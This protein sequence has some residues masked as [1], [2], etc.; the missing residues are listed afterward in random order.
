MQGYYSSE[1][2]NQEKTHRVLTVRLILHRC[3]S[4]ILTK[5]SDDDMSTEARQEGASA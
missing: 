3:I 1:E 5:I 4:P 2:L